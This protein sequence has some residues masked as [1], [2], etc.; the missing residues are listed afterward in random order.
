MGGAMEAF[1]GHGL[2][3]NDIYETWQE[4]CF[5]DEQSMD[6]THCRYLYMI[7]YYEADNTDHYA[8]DFTDC[9]DD[10]SW[11]KHGKHLKFK[12][13]SRTIDKL[14]SQFKSDDDW[15]SYT[16]K[17]IRPLFQKRNGKKNRKL[18]TR[19]EIVSFKNELIGNKQSRNRRRRLNVEWGSDN[20][21]LP[22]FEC[23]ADFMTQY[24]NQPLVQEALNVKNLEWEMCADDVF[25][26]WPEQ[27]WDNK[28][29]PYYAQLAAKYPLLKILV[30]S[31]DDDSV[32]GLH[33]TQ[34]WLDNMDE[35]G[36]KVDADNEWLPWQFDNQ[37]AGYSSTYLT[38]NGDVAL[39][40]HTVRTAGHMVPQT[41]P[42]RALGLLSKFLNEME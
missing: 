6:D 36:W 33:G 21:G 37:L 31:G 14:L 4:Y 9:A 26:S 39:Y 17:S 18:P 29:E 16:E 25:E 22:Y 2:M 24:L 12:F 32:C 13:I 5:G 8:L 11:N 15:Q 28:M 30:F 40:F 41:Q 23:A 34:Y 20:D 27:D 7:G 1:Y 38:E 3:R 42:G 35:Y 10:V 19:K